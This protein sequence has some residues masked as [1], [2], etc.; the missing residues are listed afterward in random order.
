MRAA[1]AS[2]FPVA[3]AERKL[4]FL[5]SDCVPKK[6]PVREDSCASG[7]LGAQ[8]L[9][10]LEETFIMIPF[11]RVSQPRRTLPSDFSRAPDRTS[12]DQ[13]QLMFHSAPW[14]T[15]KAIAFPP[16]P[17]WRNRIE[18]F[19]RKL[20]GAN[21]AT[22]IYKA[23]SQRSDRYRHTRFI[24]PTLHCPPTRNYWSSNL[25]GMP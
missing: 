9:R 16:K 19:S 17:R 18:P 12:R 13:S 1:H 6:H 2:P 24:F 11:E 21:K 14:R 7:R 22:D 4:A 5:F 3:R 23:P 15:S 25:R 20:F 10:F 8:R